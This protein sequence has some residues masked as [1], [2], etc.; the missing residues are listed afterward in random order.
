[1]LTNAPLCS[2]AV[3]LWSGGLQPPTTVWCSPSAHAG[4]RHHTFPLSEIL[5]E[6]LGRATGGKMG[7]E[8]RV[9]DIVDLND[10]FLKTYSERFK[11]CEWIYSNFENRLV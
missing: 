11:I 8:L 10:Y 7:F 3:S 1:M 5:A 4:A 2:G 9:E 6:F